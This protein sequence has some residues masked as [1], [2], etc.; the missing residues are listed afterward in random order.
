[1]SLAHDLLEQ[2]Q[3]L[4]T[5]DPHRPRRVNLRRAVSAAYYGLFHLLSG[6]AAALYANEFGLVA[7]IC[8]THNHGEMKRVSSLLASDKLPKGVQPPS[9]GYTAPPDL[10]T[11][12]N[13][14]VRLQQARH[15][16][17]YDLT[18]IFRRHETLALVQLAR[19]AFVAWER[20]KKSD[21]SRI[22]LACFLLWKRWDE[23]PR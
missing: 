18:R 23:D 2:A 12:A 13:A 8:R 15:E 3:H 10:K 4:A 20:V 6:E 11:V 7:R 5:L 19:Q 21:D 17:D 16:A 22:Y 14:F 1:M 9:G